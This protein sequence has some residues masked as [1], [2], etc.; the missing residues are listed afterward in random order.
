MLH[1]WTIALLAL[2]AVHDQVFAEPA[3]SG[4]PASS[5]PWSW[6]VL[7]IVLGAHAAIIALAWLITRACARR[8]DSHGSWRAVRIA[9]IAM[10]LCAPLAGVT[11]GVSIFAL[12]WLDRI[13]AVVGDLVLV[14]ELL[15]IG[16]TLAVFVLAWWAIY[17]VHR[18][19]REAVTM[20]S[21][22]EGA[23]VYAVPSRWMYTLG[24]ARNHL[25]I[26]LVPLVLISAWSE[27]L[28]RVV[29]WLEHAGRMPRVNAEVLS[30]AHAGVQLL[31]VAI[32]LALSPVLMRRVWSTTRLGPGE[33]RDRLLRVCDAAG[34]RVRELLVWRT[35][36]TMVNGAAMGIF[37]GVRYILLTDALLDQLPL[38]Q[39][40]SVMAHEAAHAKEHHLAWLG[41]S[42]IVSSTLVGALGSLAVA[43]VEHSGLIGERGSYWFEGAIT[44]VM[45]VAAA[46]VFG[47]VSRRFEWQAD[48]FAVKALSREGGAC[49]VTDEAVLAMTGALQRVAHL[50]SINMRRAS[51]R[52]GSIAHRI[53]RLSRLAGTQ[54]SAMP[55]DRTARRIKLATVLGVLLVGGALAFDLWQ[56]SRP[57]GAAPLVERTP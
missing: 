55:I 40:E 20:R 48:A 53:S 36:G 41:T 1:L 31:G 33:L 8:M 52:H 12:G 16:P 25:L 19:I 51:F 13:R 24:S 42:V 9:E 7:G 35:H 43:G 15:C 46:L 3:S 17:P 5:H 49:T 4:P 47:V 37:P 23:P 6:P 2:I 54:L 30:T 26:S 28:D 56:A 14:D 11:L 34:V 32:V 10:S 50:N 57:D 45:L 39:V 29:L 21:L 18:R 27:S 22:D 44:L 38:R